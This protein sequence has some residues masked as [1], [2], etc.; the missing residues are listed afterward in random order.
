MGASGPSTSGGTNSG[1]RTA[2]REI[3]ETRLLD[4]PRELV[5]KLWTEPQHIS[6]WWGPRGFTTTT[7]EMDV[8]PGGVW[9]HVMHG[10]DGRNYPNR[11]VYVEVVKPER[12][13][14]DHESHPPF[15]TTVIFEEHGVKT[16]ISMRMVFETAEL[17]NRTD[18]Q[19]GAVEGLKQ[20]LARLGEQAMKSPVVVERTF[21]AP[22]TR[23]WK[24]ITEIDEM[25]H[26]FMKELTS[27]K[28]EAGF[29]T[30]F[31]V[32]HEGK[33]YPHSWKVIEVV[34]QRKVA[35]EWRFEGHSG[36]SVATMELFPEGIR[37]RLR[38]T[39]AG[40]D[41]HP[42]DNPAFARG[43]FQEGWNAIADQLKGYMEK[44]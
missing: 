2:D 3:F 22:V 15:R 44:I 37:T 18:R 25:K 9:L 20:T 6:N 8:R 1:A 28:A 42:Q 10:P 14:Y 19:H 23:V 5:W 30:S 29:E 38:V 33:D 31:N 17:R 16:K 34:P 21:D 12:I 40:I 7:S 32:R 11:I 35:V 24:A 36:V 26:W 4:A 27:F 43:S 13:V 39:H 41:S